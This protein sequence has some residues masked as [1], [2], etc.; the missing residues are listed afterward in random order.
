MSQKPALSVGVEHL[1]VVVLHVPALWHVSGDVQVTVLWMVQAPA[2]QLVTSHALPLLQVVPFVTGEY[3]DVL[4]LGWHVSQVFAPLVAPDATHAPAMSQKPALSVGVG[5]LP[6][7]VLHVPAVWHVSGDV[8]VTWLCTV[9]VP[10]WQLDVSQAFPLLHVVPFVTGE[11][12]VVLTLGWH[13]SQVFVPLAAPAATQALPMKQK[14]GLSVAGEQ[15]PLVV[16]QA[17]AV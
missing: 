4:T 10:A 1:P 5:H 15:V 9:Q 13:V 11:Y 14:P 6:V 17:P 2:W 16:L 3:P 12:A 7:V 8:Q